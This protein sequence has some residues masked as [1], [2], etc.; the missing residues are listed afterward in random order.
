MPKLPAQIQFVKV[1]KNHKIVN[2][3]LPNYSSISGIGRYNG[4]WA[5][6][7]DECRKYIVELLINGEDIYKL[8]DAYEVHISTIK[9][10]FMRYSSQK[11][12]NPVQKNPGRVK[13]V[14]SIWRSL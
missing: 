1:K 7:N 12:I 13:G 5:R 9:I 3:F 14:K 11:Y 10:W 4:K 2:P 6:V 8:A